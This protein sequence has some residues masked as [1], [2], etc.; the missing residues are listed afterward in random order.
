M[1]VI[2]Q[3]RFALY[4]DAAWIIVFAGAGGV[5]GIGVNILLA[6]AIGAI[7]LGEVVRILSMTSVMALP[8]RVLEPQLAYWVGKTQNWRHASYFFQ[9]SAFSVGMLWVMILWVLRL[10][11]TLVGPSVVRGMVGPLLLMLLPMFVPPVQYAILW[12]SNRYRRMALVSF[13]P[14]GIRAL[15]LVC[16]VLYIRSLTVGDVMWATAVA[17][18]TALVVNFFVVRSTRSG[19]RDTAT[20]ENGEQLRKA[21]MLSLGVISGIT[22]GWLSWDVVWMTRSLGRGVVGVLGVLSTFGKIPFHLTSGI[23][24]QG[25]GEQ[26]S[27]KNARRHIW[28]MIGVTTLV[29]LAILVM[30][31]EP[32]TRLF[33]LNVAHMPEL[34]WLAAIYGINAAFIG[35]WYHDAIVAVYRRSKKWV[36]AP[37]G[38][39]SWSV[40]LVLMG[41]LVPEMRL[42]AAISTL[43]LCALLAWIV[44]IVA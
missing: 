26:M 21:D 34:K 15:V 33:R 11:Q 36:Y 18:E 20:A 39:V 44:Q 6:Q 40:A 27:G 37:V 4:A 29:A 32:I 28:F 13:L 9:V 5:L 14:T 31:W 17:W 19:T 43:A 35:L 12:G 41:S 3:F 24:N 10:P 23:A 22:N 16:A 30:F 38:I 7:G 25:I 1:G 42:W 8:A 2:R